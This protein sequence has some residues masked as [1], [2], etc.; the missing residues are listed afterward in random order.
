MRSEELL[1]IVQ[2]RPFQPY[3][4]TF[5]GGETYDL[6]HPEMM[7]VGRSLVA[8]GR[9]SS[10]DER[11]AEGIFHVSLLHIVKVEPVNL[12]K[13]QNGKKRKT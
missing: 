13:S 11:I 3:R 2:R 7:M 9:P 6:T 8:F 5:T 10:T 12:P 1:D 4:F